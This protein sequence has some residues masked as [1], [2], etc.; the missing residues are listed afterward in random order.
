[1]IEVSIDNSAALGA[2]R[3]QGCRPTCLVFV[4]SDINSYA[5]V[6]GELS[7]EY[8][9]HHAA[10]LTPNWNGEGFMVST[11]THAVETFGQPHESLHPYN[12][13]DLYAPKTPPPSNLQPFYKVKF[14]NIDLGM[15][16]VISTIEKGNIVG[17]AVA[18]TTSLYY[19]VDNLVEFES[20]VL[21][22]EYHA[23]VVTGLGKHKDSTELYFKVR[24]S[25][26]DAWGVGG[27]AWLPKS[28][29]DL[30]LYGTFSL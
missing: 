3:N 30:H 7:V 22:G 9:A 26:G 5:N 29:L 14:N 13:N 12:I 21:P 27:Y 19:P 4:V 24:N 28:Y 23:L 25:W 20:N 8:L 17:I 6:T 2:V 18:V 1:M 11:V 16:E 10:N 15:D